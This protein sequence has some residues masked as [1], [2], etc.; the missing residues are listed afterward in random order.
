MK[1]EHFL[2]DK[3]VAQI[4]RQLFK[5]SSTQI[6]ALNECELSFQYISRPVQKIHR[7]PESSGASYLSGIGF[8]VGDSESGI[9][10]EG[11]GTKL[12]V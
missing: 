8:P 2:I 11:L 4:P 7:P 6:P 10:S 1:Q 9:A 12:Q 3:F 5:V